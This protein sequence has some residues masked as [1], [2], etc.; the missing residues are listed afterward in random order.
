[1]TL[2]RLLLVVVVLLGAASVVAVVVA[3]ARA[4][5]IRWHTRRLIVRSQALR[6]ALAR[7]AAERFA[8]VDRLLDELRAMPEP[9]GPDLLDD[10]LRQAVAGGTVGVRAEELPTL[11]DEV[12]ARLVRVYAAAGL[13]E[14][15]EERVRTAPGWRER[16]DSALVLGWLG[17]PRAVV[18]LAERLRD[19]YEDETTVKL[20]A[21][22]A[23]GA[24]RA[25]G[26]ATHLLAQ[27][28]DPDDWSSPRI[29][30]ALVGLGADAVLPSVD[31]LSDESANLRS[32][33]AQVL[34][35]L[36]AR[37]A[38][39]ALVARLDD[40]AAPV[41]Y[42]AAEALGRLEDR[43]AVGRLSEAVLRDP[44][45]QVRAAAADALGRIG[46]PAALTALVDAFADGD[47]W[48][49]LQ[50]VEAVERLRPDDPHLLLLGLRDESAE[51]CRAAA[52][53][54]ERTGFVARWLDEL[55]D[56][57]GTALDV[58]RSRLLDVARRGNRGALL[59]ASRGHSDFRVRSRVA[60]LLGDAGH[61]EAV[62]TLA[63]AARD[64]EWPVRA[65]AIGA[66]ARCSPVDPTPAL[67]CLEDGEETVRNAAI[68]ALRTLSP[69]RSVPDDA[70]P[71]LRRLAMAA[72][73]EMRTAVLDVLAQSRPEVAAEVALRLLDD[74]SDDLRAR[75]LDAVAPLRSPLAVGALARALRDPSTRVRAR[76]AQHLGDV[77]TPDA[78]RALVHATFDADAQTREPI[79]QALARRGYAAIQDVLDEFM[80][81]PAEEARLAVL[82]TLGK[83]GDPRVVPLLVASLGDDRPRVRRSAAGA[84]ARFDDEGA[85]AALRDS[86]RDPD[87]FTRA[88][89]VNALA[90]LGRAEDGPAVAAALEDPD[91]FVRR[92]ALIAAGR[93]PIP[94]ARVAAFLAD[95]DLGPRAAA[96]LA[97]TG[98]EGSLGLALDWLREAGHAEALAAALREER[99]ELAEAVRKAL[100]LF[101]DQ[102]DDAAV[103]AWVERVRSTLATARDPGERLR[104]LELLR[105]WPA[106]RPLDWLEQTIASDPDPAV[107]AR[108]VAALVDRGQAR[109]HLLGRAL[110]D[111]H[112]DVRAAAVLG[113]APWR[114][115]GPNTLA[116]A[117]ASARLDGLAATALAAQHEGD[118]A[119][120]ADLLMGATRT[121]ERG[122][123]VRAIGL[124][125]PLAVEAVPL[126]VHLVSEPDGAL[127]AAVAESLGRI[128]GSE[129][130]TA[131]RGLLLDPDA[132]VRVL[133]VASMA[134]IDPRGLV[135][136]A[137]RVAA[138]P[139]ETVRAAWLAALGEGAGPETA[140]LLGPLLADPHPAVRRSARLVLLR[141]GDE[142]LRSFA[143]SLATLDPFEVEP[144]REQVRAELDR[145]AGSLRS[146][147]REEVRLAAVAVIAWLGQDAV[148]RAAAGLGDPSA[149]VRLAAVRVLSRAGPGP[150]RE[151]LGALLRDPDAQIRAAAMAGLAAGSS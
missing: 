63:E 139:S 94:Q 127:R 19:P 21:A 41:R 25:P 137:E 102:P 132:R 144:L 123:A 92:R 91:A 116:L 98:D 59:Q 52:S 10:A 125:G 17:D 113:A 104:A 50:A 100:G 81:S 71:L 131:A 49:R 79:A 114:E 135:A 110:R 65:T 117:G 103:A 118:P 44:V 89:S 26:T 6:E 124:L 56:A 147:P 143:A 95:R 107:R 60:E 40:R 68:E 53:A 67:L 134:A 82:W 88:A 30:E 62:S 61:P 138:D 58:A 128:G 151:G 16:A 39:P 38:V 99:T 86:L 33:A 119:G 141:A 122:V 130:A 145:V 24:I 14:R 149:R 83:V 37:E 84:L 78:L 64:P 3:G 112:E 32:W 7:H 45:G 57:R 87:A 22:R 11:D 5:W 55:R 66:W 75:A 34:G 9:V 109:P 148:E 43:R 48:T 2:D 96:G 146:S 8:S 12:R 76:A 13:F 74:P 54:L 129:A 111:P 106:D 46:D 133:A 72:N 31:A 120:L 15:H 90:G 150:I 142:G 20:A 70:L 36:L 97:L 4:A 47:A 42:A 73:V 108:A 105:A 29:A 1:M 101:P 126:L 27:L 121:A 69:L 85:R 93:L 136:A 140:A 77:G 28:R 18:P 115:L 35:R 51:V 23:L 80:A